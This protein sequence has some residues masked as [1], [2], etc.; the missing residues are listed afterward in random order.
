MEIITIANQ[1]GGVGKTTTA[2]N[3]A[4]ALRHSG[5][6]TL[7]IDVDPQ[8]NSTSS[9]KAAIED[10]YTMYDLFKKECTA[11]E[12]IQ[13]T[14]FGDIIAGDPN[15]SSIEYEL[16]TSVGGFRILKK[17]LKKMK[18]AY[19]YVV[20]DTPPNLGIYMLNALTAADKVIVPIKAEK[21]AIDGLQRLIETIGVVKEEEN[22]DLTI[23]G[24]LLTT[25]DRRNELDRKLWET[26]PEV[27]EAI[28]MP[29]FK[30][31][32]RISQDVKKA[33]DQVQSLFDTYPNSNAAYDYAMITKELI[34]G[35]K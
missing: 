26:L 11:D 24:I 10:T 35:D 12:A 5:Y 32:I 4:D 16:Q 29:V 8:T 33:Q 28:G 25:Y 17:A 6:A 3:I 27:G 30:S 1:K 23:A 14:E 9:Y 19:D 7:F 22:P 18:A 13:H 15:L 2:L 34:E 31:P 20:V 21:Y